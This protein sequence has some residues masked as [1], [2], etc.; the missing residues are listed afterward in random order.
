MLHLS[1]RRHVFERG[2]RAGP[3]VERTVPRAGQA[4]GLWRRIAG[5]IDEPGCPHGDGGD[6][7]MLC[8][9]VIWYPLPDANGWVLLA[10]V[11]V[12]GQPGRGRES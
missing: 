6:A 5:R 9:S 7:G 3:H 1:E 2:L 10:V 8:A 4:R 12:G 11:P